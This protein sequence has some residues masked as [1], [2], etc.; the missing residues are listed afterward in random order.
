M[1]FLELGLQQ[2]KRRLNWQRRNRR[3]VRLKQCI[4]AQL[5]LLPIEKELR[6]LLDLPHWRSL[7]H[8]Q[9]GTAFDLEHHLHLP[10]ALN[11]LLQSPCRQ[12]APALNP[13]TTW[14]RHE[15]FIHTSPSVSSHSSHHPLIQSCPV[16]TD[17]CWLQSLFLSFSS[18]S[19]VTL[20]LFYSV[21]PNRTVWG[22]TELDGVEWQ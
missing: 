1:F 18:C 11:S 2:C 14:Q 4:R 8:V 7:H 21:G 17:S 9:H 13:P 19:S 15:G 10:S 22:W 12:G 16:Y 20:F 3:Q 5:L 6:C